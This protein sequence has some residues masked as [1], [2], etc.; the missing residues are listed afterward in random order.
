MIALVN[1]RRR[2]GDQTPA[3]RDILVPTSRVFGPGARVGILAARGAGKS[4]LA[5]LLCG[6]EPPDGGAVIREGR[7]SWPIGAAG[8]LHPDLGV[9]ENLDLV[10]QLL[11]AD[12]DE[13]IAF[14][15]T[16]SGLETML[17]VPVK[18]LSP[19]G[20]AALAFSLA[21]STACDTYIADDVTGFGTGPQRAL[22]EAA[23]ERRLSVAGLIL[24]A[25]NPRTIDRFCD[26][27]LALVDAHLVPCPDTATA[28]ALVDAAQARALSQPGGLT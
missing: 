14:C 18:A 6:I 11:G 9:A 12:P 21:L 13:T 20:R 4:T 28:M 1:A 19:A 26:T 16:L 27:V 3:A 2:I 15:A 23:L 10:A 8:M 17:D 25:S 5:R 24:L 7:V 22:S